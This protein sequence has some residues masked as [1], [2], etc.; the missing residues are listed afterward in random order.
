M[1][2]LYQAL[3]E[4]RD[5]SSTTFRGSR[6][7]LTTVTAR[8]LM[9][10]MVLLFCAARAF[11]L[12]QAAIDLTVA[13]GAY[14]RYWLALATGAAC[15]VES[16]AVLP[17][18]VRRGRLSAGGLLAE[19]AFDVAALAAL[20]A[21][22]TADPGRGAA[23]NWMLQYS[24]ATCAGL[25]LVAGADLLATAGEEGT[26]QPQTSSG[27]R[28]AWSSRARWW[29]PVVVAVL[30]ASYAA[31]AL[32]PATAP[33][34]SVPQVIVD[35]VNFPVFFAAAFAATTFLR[36]VLKVIARR[37]A[38]V[39]RAAA[40]LAEKSQWR[41]VA[42]DVFAPVGAL[43]EALSRTSGPVPPE[44]QSEAGRLIE[45]IEAVRPATEVTA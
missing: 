4:A 25:G 14:T 15:V 17:A 22:T 10:A 24:V 8:R 13:G 23:I 32:L 26:G 37:N 39:A 3:R 34:E 7:L 29:A 9:L 30:M 5:V 27:S 43:L 16:A 31:G 33:G 11:H 18:F 12:C 1:P 42:V 6:S 2:S 19:A 40:V 20:S 36:R 35:T 44:M 28:R 41:A 45:L 38:D 21:A